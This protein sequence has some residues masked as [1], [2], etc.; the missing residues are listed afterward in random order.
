MP[1][2]TVRLTIE[3][4]LATLTLN[5]PDRLNSLTPAMGHVLVAALDEALE[6]GARA[7]AGGDTGSATGCGSAPVASTSATAALSKRSSSSATGSSTR[8]I[9]ATAAVPGMMQTSSAV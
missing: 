9:P 1:T 2:D 3:D 7:A 5:R 4:G 8:V 6:G